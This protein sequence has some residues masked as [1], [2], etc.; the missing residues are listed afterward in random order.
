M[1]S[2]KCLGLSGGYQDKSGLGGSAGGWKDPRPSLQLTMDQG[3]DLARRAVISDASAP[4][5]ALAAP[6]LPETRVGV[7]RSCQ[8][9]GSSF[10]WLTTLEGS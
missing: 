7:L 5:T 2:F 6:N 1:E 3:Q 10:L 4:I 9:T 8:P